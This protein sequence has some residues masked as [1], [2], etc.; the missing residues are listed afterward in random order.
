MNS[1]YFLI[2]GLLLFASCGN[3]KKANEIVQRGIDRHGLDQL[4]TKKI[5]FDFR[6]RQYEVYSEDG[7]KVYTRSYQDEKLGLI[8]D[9]LINSTEFERYIEGKKVVVDEEWSVKYGSSVNSVLYFFKLPYGLINGA[10]NKKYEG[11]SFIN[12][13]MYETVKVTFDQE[14]GGKDYQDIFVFWFNSKTGLMDFLAY[15]YETDGGGI[16]FREAINRRKIN[17]LLVQDYI[18]YEPTNPKIDLVDLNEAF[19]KGKMK[20]LSRIINTNVRII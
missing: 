13:E 16:R 8:K 4:K 3:E 1:L 19:E 7:D 18:N 12:G 14:G 6:D 9:V 17:G 15:S 2:A 20:E 11:Q 10:V 5:S